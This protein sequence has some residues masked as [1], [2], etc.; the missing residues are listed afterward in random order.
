MTHEKEKVENKISNE[1]T[2]EV[3]KK[4]RKIKSSGQKY[5]DEN[6]KSVKRNI[7][8]GKQERKEVKKRNIRTKLNV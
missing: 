3:R 1:L 6:I 5:S 4:K 2:I 8:Q 7:D